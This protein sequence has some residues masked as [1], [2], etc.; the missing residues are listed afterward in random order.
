MD[1]GDSDNSPTPPESTE[2]SVHGALYKLH[3]IQPPSGY[4]ATF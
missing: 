2:G 1:H 3:Q 4:L